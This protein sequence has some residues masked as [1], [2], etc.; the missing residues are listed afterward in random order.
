MSEFPHIAIGP[1]Y[2]TAVRSKLAFFCVNY[3]LFEFFFA[4]AQIG[5]P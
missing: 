5:S 3:D 1:P 4:T 2:M